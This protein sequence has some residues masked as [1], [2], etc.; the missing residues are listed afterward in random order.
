MQHIVD[1][2]K[3]RLKSMMPTVVCEEYFGCAK[4]AGQLKGSSKFRNAER[5]QAIAIARGV[6]DKRAIYTTVKPDVR[7]EE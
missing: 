6:L 1:F 4:N 2:A 7:A 5:S 3:K